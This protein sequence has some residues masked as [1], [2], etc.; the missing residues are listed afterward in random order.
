MDEITFVYAFGEEPRYRATC[1]D[2]PGVT[3]Q[4]RTRDELNQKIRDAVRGHF[5]GRSG[6]PR[7]VRIKTEIGVDDGMIIL[8]G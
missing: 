1:E 7:R 6:M 5:S 2:L 3:V 8:R 4:A